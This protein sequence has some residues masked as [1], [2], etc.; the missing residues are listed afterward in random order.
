M[1]GRSPRS[2]AFAIE[3]VAVD[4]RMNE[5]AGAVGAEVEVDHH[6]TVA[7]AAVDAVDDRGLDELVVLAT[8]V[9]G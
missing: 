3:F 2:N 7:D 5:L 4:E 9:P 1:R 6:V 8:G